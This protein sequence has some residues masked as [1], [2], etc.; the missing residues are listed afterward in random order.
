M[1]HR[2]GRL[3][4]ATRRTGAQLRVEPLVEASCLDEPIQHTR[5]S[6]GANAFRRGETD[7]EA[8]R[9]YFCGSVLAP[10]LRG[11]IDAD[12]PGAL[13]LFDTL[14]AGIHVASLGTSAAA[15][16]L[17]VTRAEAF[18]SFCFASFSGQDSCS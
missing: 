7:E 12:T 14:S 18:S 1:L 10:P 3:R 11:R 13:E 8:R 15:L 16:L 2:K 9:E 4:V 5:P 17:L 6:R